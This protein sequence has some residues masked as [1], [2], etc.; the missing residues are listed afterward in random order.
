MNQYQHKDIEGNTINLPVGKVLCV[1]RNYMDHIVEMGGSEGTSPQKGAPVLFMKPPSALCHFS[2]N[3]N[4][5]TDRGECHNELEV[6]FLIGKPLR[7]ASHEE[8]RA[9]LYAVA[10]GLDLTL[11][12]LQNTLKD[13]GLPWERCKSFDDSCPV[14]AFSF[15]SD[16]HAIDYTF[17]LTINNELRQDGNTDFMLWPT[18]ELLVTATKEFTLL[19]GDIVMTGTPKG[20][21]PL[22][23]GDKIEANLDGILNVS[24]KVN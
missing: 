16:A 12:D 10:L 22:F 23:S 24:T 11:R 2:E 15:L 14:S 9:A 13:A 17:Q 8:C 5:P 20:V 4:I 6:A 1:G 3:L 19:P 18:I 21:G 7:N